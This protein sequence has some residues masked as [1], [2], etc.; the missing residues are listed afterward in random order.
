LPERNIFS[1]KLLVD[2]KLAYRWADMLSK[3]GI[4]TVRWANVGTANAPD[5]EIMAYAASRNYTVLTNDLDFSAILATTHEN[6]PSVVQIRA[7]D[8]RPEGMLEQVFH[9]LTQCAPELENGA[10]VTVEMDKTR[11]RILPFK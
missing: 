3:K 5:T 6:K 7:A 11:L 8:T 10:L 2:M 1:I 4:E 9:A